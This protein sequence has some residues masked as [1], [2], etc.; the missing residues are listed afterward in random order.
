[1]KVNFSQI[2]NNINGKPLKHRDEEGNEGDLKLSDVCTNALMS[3]AEQDK[4]ENGVKKFKRYQLA[5]KIHKQDEV[6]VTAE[7]V[8]LL[9]EK[10]GS[11]YGPAVIGPCYELL[12]GSK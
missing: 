8:S 12:E 6:E 3:L 9:K 11:L 7:E 2:L 4:N 5:T 1:M 10:I